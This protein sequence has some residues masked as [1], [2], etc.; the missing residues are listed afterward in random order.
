MEADR[1]RLR[2][3][4]EMAKGPARIPRDQ[5]DELVRAWNDYPD[6]FRSDLMLKWP[7]LF[8]AV[9]RMVRRFELASR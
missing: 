1:D 8:F 2:M 7:D 4:T 6:D 3:A 9:S 5:I